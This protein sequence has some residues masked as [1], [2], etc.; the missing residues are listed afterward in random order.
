MAE[1]F[2]RSPWRILMGLDQRAVD[3]F[4]PLPREAD[5]RAAGR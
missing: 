4:R 3:G 5:H 2:F 1:A